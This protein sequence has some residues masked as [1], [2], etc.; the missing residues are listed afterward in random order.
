VAFAGTFACWWCRFSISLRVRS[1][2]GAPA[3]VA[4]SVR[5]RDRSS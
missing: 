2:A 1:V 5:W 3:W 4:V